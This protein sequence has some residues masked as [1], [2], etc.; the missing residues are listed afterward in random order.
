MNVY[1]IGY[2]GTGKSSVAGILAELL[3]WNSVDTDDLIK[4][5]AGR[6]I[7]EIF[8]TVGEA[9]F[10]E[11]E[12]EVIAE[13]STQEQVVVALGGGAV[14]REQNRDVIHASGKTVWLQA[15]VTTIYQRI[16]ADAATSSQRPNLSA[17]GGI[18]EIQQLLTERTPIYR[19]C[20]DFKLDTTDKSPRQIAN[21]I[22]SLLRDASVV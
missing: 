6:S 19:G 16:S 21:E 1:L 10:R 2:R 7:K 5:K 12:T 20:A 13:V 18:E 14:L 3:N 9:G 15:D 4:T 8:E 22:V 17:A 11:L